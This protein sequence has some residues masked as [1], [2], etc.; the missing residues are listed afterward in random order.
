MTHPVDPPLG[1]VL[2]SSRGFDGAW[3]HV[4][5]DSVRL[6]SGRIATREVLEHPGAV[7]IVAITR[8]SK[9]LLLRQ[10]HHPIQRVL[11]GLPAGTLEPGEEP[12]ACAR[13][14]LMEETGY[15]A[16]A[17][18]RIA[19]YFTSP[20]YTSEQLTIFLAED[21]S[22]A[23]GEIDPDELIAVVPTPV[24]EIPVLV[25]PGPEQVQDAKTLIGLLLL[26]QLHGLR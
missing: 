22:F 25:A 5:V 18:T 4:R 12:E 7:A 3:L 20:G 24:H 23:A 9:V 15:K 13:R 17:M 19:S 16:G 1:V 14:E 21:C 2:S 26:C 11:L 8:D 6:P 10:A